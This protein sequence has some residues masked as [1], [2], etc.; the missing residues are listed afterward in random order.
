MNH[1]NCNP[2]LEDGANFVAHMDWN[3]NR[4]GNPLIKTSSGLYLLLQQLYLY[5]YS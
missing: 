2:D 1:K 3:L 4:K 5:F